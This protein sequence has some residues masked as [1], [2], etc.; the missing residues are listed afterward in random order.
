MTVVSLV[1]IHMQV[2][3]IE[4]AYLGKQKE[5]RLHQ[6]VKLNEH[7]TY[8]ILTL[9]SANN[10]GVQMLTEKSNMLFAEPDNVIEI[11]SDDQYLIESNI[12]KQL[13][14]SSRERSLLSRLTFTSMA[15]TEMQY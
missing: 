9:K 5:K 10:L 6:L 15:D 14:L 12:A 11:F 4:L 7:F 3:I 2:Q 13:A 8:K 1:Y